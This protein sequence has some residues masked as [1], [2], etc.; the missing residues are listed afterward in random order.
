MGRTMLALCVLSAVGA[1]HG[2][3]LTRSRAPLSRA[4]G[5]LKSAAASTRRSL[6]CVDDLVSGQGSTKA[7]NPLALMPIVLPGA[8]TFTDYQLFPLLNLA[9]P[10]WILLA[11]LP[12][13][14]LSRA[15]ARYTALAFSVLYVLLLVP[16]LGASG[17][18]SV[19][20]M[21]S[22]DGLIKL[23]KDPATVMVGWVHY[24]AFDLW[25]ALWMVT[26]ASKLRVD[27]GDKLYRI[28]HLVVLPCLVCT[29][30]AGPLGLLSYSIIRAGILQYR[31]KF[32][33]RAGAMY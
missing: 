21:G 9:L 33:K 25:T 7:A 20:D 14:K 22:L 18:G 32:A 17:G 11:V 10:A 5:P 23:F 16:L 12:R 4:L 24:I 3:A 13:S 31:A 28:P 15:V 6:Q 27:R 26:D 1:A 29:L 8:I 19:A 30:M 2:S